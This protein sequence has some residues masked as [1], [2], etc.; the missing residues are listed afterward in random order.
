MSEKELQQINHETMNIV[1][2]QV[3]TIFRWWPLLFALGTSVTS[4]AAAAIVG[5]K[6]NEALVKQPEF[7]KVINENNRKINRDSVRIDKVEYKVDSI[8]S[9]NTKPHNKNIIG[10]GIY[11]IE[12]TIGNKTYLIRVDK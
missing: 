6:Y 8:D 11:Y 7:R 4:I 2:K 3:A 10:L 1:A 12:K 5:Y 9:V